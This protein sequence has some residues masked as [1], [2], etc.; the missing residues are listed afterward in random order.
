MLYIHVRT[1]CT[2]YRSYTGTIVKL[3]PWFFVPV[4][5]VYHTS[6]PTGAYRIF[7]GTVPDS[8]AIFSNFLTSIQFCGFDVLFWLLI[9]LSCIWLHSKRMTTDISI[10]KVVWKQFNQFF[11]ESVSYAFWNETLF[12]PVFQM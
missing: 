3:V 6:Y 10:Q 2:V 1:S 7:T 11:Y 8:R 5:Y 4:W 12:L 9:W